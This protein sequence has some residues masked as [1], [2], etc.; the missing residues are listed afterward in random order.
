MKSA[1]NNPE[2]C[3]YCNTPLNIYNRSIDH[4]IPLAR[5]GENKTYN[6]VYACKNCNNLKMDMTVTEFN[7]YKELKE[8][9]KGKELVDKC[10]EEGILLWTS[11]RRIR[12]KQEKERREYHRKEG[13]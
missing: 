3:Y 13:K 11:D 7:R 2:R 10:K 5:G 6:R 12:N 1:L 4:L 9:Y 8:K